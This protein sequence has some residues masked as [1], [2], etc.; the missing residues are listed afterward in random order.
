LG[1]AVW[2]GGGATLDFFF[3]IGT[4]G[5]SLASAST[6]ELDVDVQPS[7]VFLGSDTLEDVGA[8]FAFVDLPGKG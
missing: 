8:S 4:D 7:T 2:A 1:G 3:L 6:V 5:E